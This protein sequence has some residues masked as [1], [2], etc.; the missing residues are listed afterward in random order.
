MSIGND[1]VLCPVCKGKR[2]NKQCEYCKGEGRT[3]TFMIDYIDKN[4]REGYRTGKYHHPSDD[5]HTYD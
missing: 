5:Y 1:I 2:G 4:I 3:T